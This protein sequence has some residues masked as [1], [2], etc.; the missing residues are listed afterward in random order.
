MDAIAAAH[1]A[2]SPDALSAQSLETARF[3]DLSRPITDVE[4]ESP[5]HESRIP[6][7]HPESGH[8]WTPRRRRHG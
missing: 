4:Q 6:L 5:P 8:P 7:V 2:V 1:T 3:A